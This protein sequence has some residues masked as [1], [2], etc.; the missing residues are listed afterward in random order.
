M[1]LVTHVFSCACGAVV[2]TKPPPGLTFGLEAN[3][4]LLCNT[5][6]VQLLGELR[7]QLAARPQATPLPE[8]VIPD[9]VAADLRRYGI[10][11]GAPTDPLAAFGLIDRVD[12]IGSDVIDVLVDAG[13]G[14][15]TGIAIEYLGNA[16]NAL[17]ASSK[18]LSRTRSAK[19]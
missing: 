19:P 13:A 1:N 14:G 16:L 10:R 9:V 5:C 12:A 18:H 8:A 4:E 7:M 6:A 2:E 17:L 15:I 11:M 3:E